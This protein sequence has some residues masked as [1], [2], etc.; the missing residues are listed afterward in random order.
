MSVAAAATKRQPR[1][2]A[3]LAAAGTKTIVL[4]AGSAVVF[5]ALR[6]V[7]LANIPVARFP[8]T[9]TYDAVNFLGDATRL[10][11]VPLLWELSPDDTAVQILLGTVAWLTL[12]IVTFKVVR[13]Q[14]VATAGFLLIL[15]LG[16]CG[17][18]TEWDRALLSESLT[19][20]TLL[21][22]VSALLLLGERYSRA[23]VAFLLVAITAW[24]FARHADAWLFV[25]IGPPA[26]VALLAT[27]RREL[28]LA[29]ALPLTVLAGWAAFAIHNENTIWKYNATAV[30]QLRVL[31]DQAQTA[32]FRERGMPYNARIQA[33]ADTDTR[34]R[35]DTP[36]LRNS[37]LRSWIGTDFRSTYAQYLATHPA[38]T[39]EKPARYFANGMPA[40]VG[41]TD[42]RE[43]I[44]GPVRKLLWPTGAGLALLTLLSLVLATLALR[45]RVARGVMWIPLAGI[46]VAGL[47]GLLT[48]HQSATEVARLFAPVSLLLHV[49]LLLTLLFAVDGLVGRKRSVPRSP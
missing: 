31:Q 37:A 30:I 39:A 20:S 28:I 45:A 26:I 5:V 14:R 18:A 16:L 33:V 3:A 40:R 47:W 1:L 23:R 36:L 42:P 49:S 29:L 41:Y 25:L 34:F 6:L 32:Y 43:P 11:A 27:R 17:A 8:D 9:R 15:G 4:L 35:S 22:V 7:A 12:A 10:W 46:A 2:P 38:G 48:W 24:L 21:F 13:D 44:P 19:F